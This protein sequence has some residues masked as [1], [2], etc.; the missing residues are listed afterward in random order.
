MQSQRSWLNKI[1]YNGREF[2]WPLLEHEPKNSA[3]PAPVPAFELL[4]ESENLD[5]FLSL[6]TKMSESE[7][8]RRKGIESKASLFISTISVATSIVVAANAMV[9]SGKNYG[10]AIAISVLISFILS[11]YAAR[12]VWFAVKAL[13]RGNYSVLGVS[14]INFKGNKE[15]YQKHLIDCLIKNRKNNLQTVNSKVDSVTMAQEYY[16]RAIIM[17][18][19][20][21]CYI[22]FQCIFKFH[23]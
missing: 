2:I 19:I 4:V 23:R 18:C 12:T 5:Q 9:V 14:E 7:D 20:Y 17:I 1:I 22:L 16:K 13:E 11:I 15:Q 21:S 8:D 10:F 3:P 6:T